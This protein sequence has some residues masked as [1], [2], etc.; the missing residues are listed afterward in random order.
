MGSH[1]IKN[2]KAIILEVYV[3]LLRGKHGN[4]KNCCLKIPI[5]RQKIAKGEKRT[6]VD[7]DLIPNFLNLNE[8]DILRVMNTFSIPTRTKHNIVKDPKTLAVQYQ[9]MLDEGKVQSKAELS[10]LLGVSRARV[11]QVLRRLN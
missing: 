7:L 1:K 9:Q 4:S 6:V 2:P 8:A 5:I 3:G 11:T 10:R